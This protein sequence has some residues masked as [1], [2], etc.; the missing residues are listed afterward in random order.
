MKITVPYSKFIVTIGIF[1]LLTPIVLVYVDGP[2]YE[3][4]ISLLYSGKVQ[5][6]LS[7]NT[8]L[9]ALYKSLTSETALY[10]MS[11]GSLVILIFFDK[12][13]SFGRRAILIIYL[14][15]WLIIL[16]YLSIK[17]KYVFGRCIPDICAQL[18]YL[19]QMGFSGFSWLNKTSG[20]ASFPSGHCL[21]SVFC[22]SWA[23]ILW[24]NALYFIGIIY[25]LLVIGLVA[26]RFHFLSDC[27]AGSLLGITLAVLSML[28]WKKVFK[29]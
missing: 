4:L 9:H 17:L 24:P 12:L 19:R 22:L 25:M 1:L 16:S 11:G 8:L 2:I 5:P 13:Y 20:F 27:C 6:G 29:G 10:I 3:I 21:T 26:F 18:G 7:Q 28:I 23:F 14:V 15:S